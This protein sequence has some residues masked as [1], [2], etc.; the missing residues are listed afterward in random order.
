MKVIDKKSDFKLNSNTYI[1]LGSFD[2]LHK[3]HISLIEK[4]RNLAQKNNALS[5]VYTFKN[6]PLTVVNKKAVPKLLMDNDTKLDV[7]NK[8]N[9]DIVCMVEFDEKL[10]KMLPDAFIYSLVMNYNMAGVVVGFNYRFGHKNAGNSEYLK[11]LGEKNNFEV[12]VMDALKINNEVASSS[13]IRNLI[14]EGMIEKANTMLFQPFAIKGKVI[15]GKRLGRTLGFPTANIEPQKGII[16]PKCGVYYTNVEINKSLYKS[17]TNVGFNPTVNG[18]NLSI[19]TYILN[20][21]KDIY[22]EEIK[23]VFINRI[24]D[25]IKFQSIDELKNALIC[26]R[27]Y[28][29]NQKK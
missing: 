10:M 29:E 18:N 22:N 23:V 14:F 16:Y 3:G 13:S 20:F 28:A 8:L 26:D 27:I 21:D 15:A 1:A 7:L 12:Y 5:M 17:I 6:H 24:R 25:E 2:G 4:T 19:E 9:I 11:C